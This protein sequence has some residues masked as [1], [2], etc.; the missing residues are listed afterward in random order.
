MEQL[1]GVVTTFG[2]SF[3]TDPYSIKLSQQGFYPLRPIPYPRS[4]P[5]PRV[6]RLPQS[7]QWQKDSRAQGFREPECGRGRTADRRLKAE[8]GGRNLGWREDHI[9]L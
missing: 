5:P 6:P 7:S 4:V 3:F 1:L 8:G 9:V 2:S